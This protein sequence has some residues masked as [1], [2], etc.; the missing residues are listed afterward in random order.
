MQAIEENGQRELCG[1]I[2]TFE[3]KMD[4]VQSGYQDFVEVL[5]TFQTV[6]ID[7]KREQQEKSHQ[8]RESLAKNGSLRRKDFDDMMKE[9]LAEQDESNG[10]IKDLVE[11]YLLQQS[12]IAGDLRRVFGEIRD[13]LTEGNLERIKKLQEGTKALIDDHDAKREEITRRLK[14]FR[15][16]Q[17][18]VVSNI[19][20]LLAEGNRLRIRDFKKMLEQLKSEHE[21]RV[22]RTR[23]RRQEVLDMLAE[24]QNQRLCDHQV[25]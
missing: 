15:E 23:E 12:K 2:S 24:F 14:D 22:A 21:Q 20:A 18:E 13:A 9:I 6:M 19:R 3:D 7:G 17:E 8:L 5:N 1:I 10:A 11:K 16:E 25:G 4:R